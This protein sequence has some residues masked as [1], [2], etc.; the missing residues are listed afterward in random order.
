MIVTAL[1]WTVDG[2]RHCR[3]DTACPSNVEEMHRFFLRSFPENRARLVTIDIDDYEDTGTAPTLR[4]TAPRCESRFSGVQCDKLR[5]DNGKHTGRTGIN[6]FYWSDETADKTREPLPTLP[7]APEVLCSRCRIRP[8]TH[9]F[10][11]PAL[12]SSCAMTLD[13]SEGG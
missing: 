5:H 6:R 3:V 10:H 9:A 11:D 8:A 12:C 2:V 7:E 4:P 1:F 13:E